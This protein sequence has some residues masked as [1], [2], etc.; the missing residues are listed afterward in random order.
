MRWILLIALKHLSEAVQKMFASDDWKMKHAALMAQSQVGEY[1]EKIEDIEPILTTIMNH[2]NHDNPRIR[3][4]C[5]HCIGQLSDDMAPEIEVKYH[6]EILPQLMARVNDP[7][8]RV[9]SHAFAGLLELKMGDV[10]NIV[11]ISNIN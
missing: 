2:I 5:L 10:E 9:L 7:I 8:P 3:Y 6:K 4:A 11:V 1:M